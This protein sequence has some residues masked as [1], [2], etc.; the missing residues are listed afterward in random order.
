MD[1]SLKLSLLDAG[2]GSEMCNVANDLSSQAAMN[3]FVG[4]ADDGK[5]EIV[6][7]FLRVAPDLVNCQTEGGETALHCAVR[8]EHAGTLGLLLDNGADVNAR[9]KSLQTPAH[10]AAGLATAD[11]LKKLLDTGK[12]DGNLVD[13]YG[14]TALARTYDAFGK[15][16]FRL[17]C[18]FSCVKCDFDISMCNGIPLIGMSAIQGDLSTTQYLIDHNVDV[19]S[20]RTIGGSDTPLILAMKN[21]HYRVVDALLAVG[22][23]VQKVG[24]QDVTPLM[25]AAE[26]NDFYFLFDNPHVDLNGIF[27]NGDTLL[28][29]AMKARSSNRETFRR[30]V[31]HPKVDVNRANKDG[32]TPLCIAALCAS[33]WEFET[34]LGAFADPHI[35]YPL[36]NA[37]LSRNLEMIMRVC[38]SAVDVNKVNKSGDTALALAVQLDL[39]VQIDILLGF[40]ADPHIGFTL[41]KAI[42]AQRLYAVEKLCKL[43]TLDLDRV[44][45][46][47]RSPLKIAFDSAN[48]AMFGQLL[49]AGCSL[50]SLCGSQKCTAL[51]YVIRY[52]N[53]V[54]NALVTLLFEHDT[55]KQ[56]VIDSVNVVDTD[57]NIALHNAIG[58]CTVAVVMKIAQYTT[59]VDAFGKSNMTPLYIAVKDGYY[60]HAK[61]LLSAGA[62]MTD[63]CISTCFPRKKGKPFLKQFVLK[64]LVDVCVGLRAKDLPVLVMLGIAKVTISNPTLQ[65]FLPPQ[66]AMWEIAKTVKHYSC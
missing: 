28:V 21:K 60:N 59:N 57:G 18:R 41:H 3:F 61:G 39:D 29:H 58:K 31:A 66:I 1:G 55:V 48:V 22:A 33:I 36:H 45:D 8:N 38:D 2:Y 54:R 30:L 37:V 56:D 32:K 7:E 12:V 5:T 53:K 20:C 4:Q 46:C 14:C 10:V 9:D 26:L 44:D 11:I 43:E 62:E 49:T 13:V 42:D 64:K 23:D 65:T 47:G 63:E 51:Q 19:N 15:A 16:I 6:K 35:G 27:E 25:C 50:Q 40:S 17:F 52:G 24:K 34:L